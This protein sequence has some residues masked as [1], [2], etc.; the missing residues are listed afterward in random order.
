MPNVQGPLPLRALRDLLGLV[1][2]MYADAV[3]SHASP[4]ELEELR[5]IGES[6][7]T[8]L[9]LAARTKPNTMGHRAAWSRAEQATKDLSALVGKYSSLQSTVRT[10]GKRVVGAPVAVRFDP[11]AKIRQ[12]TKRG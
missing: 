4:L 12:R 10:A 7:R 5:A 2:V 6:L 9:D 1:R 3:A 11:N 8:A